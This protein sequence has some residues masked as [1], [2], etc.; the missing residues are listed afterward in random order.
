ME[1]IHNNNI[2]KIIKVRRAILGITQ[3]KLASS[4]G[5]SPALIGRVERGERIPSARALRKLA[6][7]LNFDESELLIQARYVSPQ[8]GGPLRNVGA[9]ILK[10]DPYVAIE[11]SKEPLEVQRTVVAILT[12]LKSIAVGITYESQKSAH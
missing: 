8:Y 7:A 3:G 10:L 11:L 6:N 5:I 1:D 4:A 2:G 9:G 12:M